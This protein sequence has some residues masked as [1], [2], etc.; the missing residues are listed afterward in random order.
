[1]FLLPIPPSCLDRPFPDGETAALTAFDPLEKAVRQ[2]CGDTG[3]VVY[4]RGEPWPCFEYPRKNRPSWLFK[5]AS[6]DVFS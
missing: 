5:V 4:A 6:V 2:L 1:M 3:E